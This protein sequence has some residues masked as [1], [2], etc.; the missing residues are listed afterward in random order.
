MNLFRT[1]GIISE[2]LT[3]N[4]FEKEV[5]KPAD[6]ESQLHPKHLRGINV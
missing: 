4:L 1:H 2:Y 3:S 5:V 6:S